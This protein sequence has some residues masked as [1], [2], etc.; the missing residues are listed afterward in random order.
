MASVLSSPSPT[1]GEGERETSP[2]RGEGERKEPAPPQTVTAPVGRPRR[3]IPV[4]AGKNRRATA[5]LGPEIRMEWYKRCTWVPGWRHARARPVLR[6]LAEG[7]P[8]R[9]ADAGYSAQMICI[10]RFSVESWLGGEDR[11]GRTGEDA[12]GGGCREVDWRGSAGR[13]R[14]PWAAAGYLPALSAAGGQPGTRPGALGQ[15]RSFR[16]RARELDGS[17][18]HIPALPRRHR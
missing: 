10:V 4:P 17:R 6:R 14:S 18:T 8:R 7:R 5:R 3:L 11:V 9:P 16:H 2:T 13:P 1:R 15:D 12:R